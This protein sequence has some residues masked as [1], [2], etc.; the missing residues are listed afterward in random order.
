MRFARRLSGSL[1]QSKVKSRQSSRDRT[2]LTIRSRY[3]ET[4]NEIDV[5]P[6]KQKIKLDL[7]YTLSSVC[8]KEGWLE[9]FL[10]KRPI[11]YL[12]HC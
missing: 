8:L 6:A 4:S 1:T 9:K 10:I 3:T 5:P 11:P 2:S 7:S 12:R